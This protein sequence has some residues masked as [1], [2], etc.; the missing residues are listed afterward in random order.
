MGKV[1][2]RPQILKAPEDY[3]AILALVKTYEPV[4]VVAGSEDGVTLINF[5]LSRRS[6]GKYSPVLLLQKDDAQI[7]VYDCT[8]RMDPE[9]I[10]SLAEDIQTFCLEQKVP[11]PFAALTAVS[12]EEMCMYTVDQKENH[13]IDYIDFLLKIYPDH[14]LMD[15]RSIG[16]AFDVSAATEDYSSIAVLKKVVSS[17]EYNYVLGMNQTRLKARVS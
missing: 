8:L 3:D 14:V 16:K 12:V 4:L 6:G 1:T 9:D 2:S 15:F 17:M 7:P 11:G 5:I 10:T 13:G